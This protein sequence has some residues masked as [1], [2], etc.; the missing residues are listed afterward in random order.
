MWTG[1]DLKSS[2]TVAVG[3]RNYVRMS[4]SC[5][6][7]IPCKRCKSIDEYACLQGMPAC[8]VHLASDYSSWTILV[9]VGECP[10]DLGWIPCHLLFWLMIW[11]LVI[12]YTN[13]PMTPPFLN[14]C[15]LLLKCL[16]SWTTQNSMKINYSETKEMLLG[17]LSK[18]SIPPL[19]IHCNSVDCLNS[20]E[21]TLVMT[22]LGICSLALPQM[23]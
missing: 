18:L 23:A 14:L 8:R 2:S 17:L 12:L 5:F 20:L 10:S 1:C 3:L 16:L 13:M 7:K 4:G 11:W 15:P 9:W 21:F 22:C 6:V 19:V